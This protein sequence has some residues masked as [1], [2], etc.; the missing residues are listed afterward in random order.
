MEKA[1]SMKSFQLAN[2]VLFDIK[3]NTRNFISP[4]VVALK[5]GSVPGLKNS[6]IILSAHYDH[7]GIGKP[8]KGDSIFNGFIDNASGVSALLELSRC[9]SQ[10]ETKRSIIFIFT[11]AEEK[12]LL[13]SSYYCDHP[14]FPLYKTIANVNIDG[15]AFLN[16]FNSVIPVGGEFSTLNEMLNPV[17]NS[18]S[19]S[20]SD[21]YD[22]VNRQES[23]TNSDQ[24]S[25]AKAGIPSLLITE[26]IETEA[27]SLKMINWMENFYHSPF[28]DKNQFI[29]YDAMQKHLEIIFSFCTFLANNEEE[30]EWKE[31]TSFIS[32]QLRNRAEKK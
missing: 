24:F 4:N 27:A 25:F 21:V 16:D 22:V 18:L 8:V 20:K 23:F 3:V 2:S 11:T 29:N 28:D 30:P 5:E 10:V 19:I 31:A 1:N 26:D 7:L 32:I 15:L 13:G 17:L 9:L 14:V 12:G 6:Y